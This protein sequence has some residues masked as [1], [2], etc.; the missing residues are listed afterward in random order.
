MLS[1]FAI[2]LAACCVALP[3]VAQ[4]ADHTA[5]AAANP[6]TPHHAAFAAFT[7]NWDN[8]CRMP[9][10]GMDEPTELPGTERIELLCN[11]LFLKSKLLGTFMGQPFE[12]LW[13]L[14]YNPAEEK[15]STIWV[16]NQAPGASL[17]T[18]TYDAEARTWTFH[19]DSPQGPVRS[20]VVFDGPDAFDEAMYSV[21]PD[22]EGQQMMEI[23]RERAKSTVADA[24]MAISA[25]T[26]EHEQLHRL[27]G[28]W[29]A[30]M[31]MQMGPD[32]PWQEQKCTERIAAICGGKW[33]WSDFDG[34]MM[35]MPFEG[36]ALMGFDTEK[37]QFVSYWVDSFGPVPMA[38]V[39]AW[40]DEAGSLTMRGEGVDMNG[41]PMK[42]H[43]VMT[44]KD[45]D[46]RVLKMSFDTADGTQTMEIV[47]ERVK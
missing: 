39:G 25:P 19:G 5:P 32:A 45:D 12:G 9:M 4:E 35:G 38:S 42:S 31:R 3:A 37:S 34:Q 36:H 26:P 33:L 17:G 1:R 28:T 46:T 21:G 41:A 10:P 44:W 16:D 47:Y 6:V 8:V 22:G 29:D 23:T 11:G 20:V 2:P 13:V 30:T 7:G 18:G 43:E 27:V 15:Y 40:D 14:G 24:A